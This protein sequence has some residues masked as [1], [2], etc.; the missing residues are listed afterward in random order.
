MKLNSELLEGFDKEDKIL[1]MKLILNLITKE[2][3]MNK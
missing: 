1:M 3:V 2:E